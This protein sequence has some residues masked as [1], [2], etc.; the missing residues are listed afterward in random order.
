MKTIVKLIAVF[1]VAF[2]ALI[3]PASP[4]SAISVADV[5]G[6]K[7]EAPYVHRDTIGRK[8]IYAASQTQ[9]L[10]SYPL[11]SELYQYYGG[12]WNKVGTTGS[13]S[14]SYAR[15]VGHV[16]CTGAMTN[17]SFFTRAWVKYN[18]TWYYRDSRV[19]T[20]SC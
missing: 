9:S 3:G 14:G 6:L 11:Q 18:G 12:R 13:A 15:A 8:W 5:T 17:Y 10:T 7:A 4:A 20:Q 1:A 19:V 2:T 16:L